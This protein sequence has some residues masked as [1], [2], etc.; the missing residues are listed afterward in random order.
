MRQKISLTVETTSEGPRILRNGQRIAP[1]ESGED[2]L[3]LIVGLNDDGHVLFERRITT[4]DSDSDIDAIALELER[5]NTGQLVAVA[6]C[7]GFQARANARIARALEL[8]GS[9]RVHDLRPNDTLALVGRKGIPAGAAHESIGHARSASQTL[10]AD[11]LG[12]GRS[13]AIQATCGSE[14]AAFMDGPSVL[15][16]TSEQFLGRWYFMVI[17]PANPVL[18]EFD[19]Q[20][21]QSELATWLL[22]LE[23]G[24]MLASCLPRMTFRIPQAVTEAL[25]RF[26]ST[27][28]PR[29]NGGDSWSFVGFQHASPAASSECIGVRGTR[30]EATH[31][32][33]SPIEAG[34][35][36]AIHLRLDRS[37]VL[38]ALAIGGRPV[39]FRHADT[40]TRPTDDACAYAAHIDDHT[41]RLIEARVLP[42][43]NVSKAPA[44]PQWIG[45]IRP[46]G[47]AVV[48]LPPKAVRLL[49]ESDLQ[50]LRR[51]GSVRA[52]AGQTANGLTVFG[53]KDIAPGAALEHEVPVTSSAEISVWRGTA[54]SPSF[55]DIWIRLAAGDGT[56]RIDSP[57]FESILPPPDGESYIRF[58]IVELRGERQ[59]ATRLL[60]PRADD[61]DGRSL[62]DWIEAHFLPGRL[63][64]AFLARGLMAP[65]EGVAIEL[66]RLGL[67]RFGRNGRWLAAAVNTGA[68]QDWVAG[69]TQGF[70][71]EDLQ[72]CLHY[73]LFSAPAGSFN[74][75][76]ETNRGVVSSLAVD[77]KG[78]ELSQ[79]RPH[80]DLVVVAV[81]ASSATHDVRYLSTAQL[82][83]E[84]GLGKQLGSPHESAVVIL[85]GNRGH[86][87]V[88]ARQDRATLLSLGS[89]LPTELGPHDAWI[90][91]G[92]RHIGRASGIEWHA[93]G[94]ASFAARLFRQP[95][96][97]ARIAPVLVAGAA[98]LLAFTA[99]LL[100]AYLTITH[101]SM[102]PVPRPKPNPLNVPLNKRTFLVAHN[103]FASRAFDWS[104]VDAAQQLDYKEMF[105]KWQVRGFMLDIDIAYEPASPTQPFLALCH[106]ACGRLGNPIRRVGDALRIFKELLEKKGN[107]NEIIFVFIEQHFVQDA[108][109]NLLLKRTLDD[110]GVTGM[111]FWADGRYPNSAAGT[112]GL[113]LP[114]V[115][116][117]A[118]KPDSWP[119]AASLVASGRRIVMFVDR[120]N[121]KAGVVDRHIL[122]FMWNYVR[123]SQFSDVSSWPGLTKPVSEREQSDANRSFVARQNARDRSMLLL[124]HFPE[125][126]LFSH[127]ETWINTLDALKPRCIQALQVFDRL[128]N[129]LAVD[130][131]NIGDPLHFVQ[132]INS[133]GAFAEV[134]RAMGKPWNRTRFEEAIRAI[135]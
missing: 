110:A 95:D 135:S 120:N 113:Q 86:L 22:S 115:T 64:V 49:S 31:I 9:A 20:R 81:S 76:V 93:S 71:D 98:F 97:H 50:A 117:A 111:V 119:T 70:D 43:G 134:D 90:L 116:F 82:E 30:S 132:Q 92:K 131:V 124:N 8:I 80:D 13:R 96:S 102:R 24:Q 125:L 33:S 94:T 62:I 27:H 15:F 26:G 75:T 54:R 123:E 23:P 41:G 53:C 130:F 48:H 29:L 44:L 2:L 45:A 108:A 88:L 127:Y 40:D 14:G 65:R 89:N 60:S 6:L 133:I 106:G 79:A 19:S 16:R 118:G 103:A 39:E 66:E 77:G 52:N 36:Y 17:E 59:V 105:G 47:L 32:L 91:I 34:T 21:V 51:L 4:A 28:L 129:F 37:R 100:S 122:P 61:E 55:D 74:V 126:P 5:S 83:L 3:G 35:G 114:Q 112:T 63:L 69:S 67:G 42:T 68:R 121:G 56:C 109:A 12:Q 46:G 10:T 25:S 78:I 11:L 1:A 107:E 18:V 99:V 57:A 58:T 72:V 104:A 84:H 38:P 73:P 128:P 87:E 101:R 85:A 7:A